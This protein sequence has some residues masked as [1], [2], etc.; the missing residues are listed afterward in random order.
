MAVTVQASASSLMMPRL[1]VFIGLSPNRR[2]PQVLYRLPG[3]FNPLGICFRWAF[4]KSPHGGPGITKSILVIIIE[5][6]G[7]FPLTGFA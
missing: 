1:L 6:A 3:R 5:H 7:G 4:G 2:G